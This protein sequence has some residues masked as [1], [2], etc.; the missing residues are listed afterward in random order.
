MSTV[1]ISTVDSYDDNGV[2]SVVDRSTEGNNVND[3]VFHYSRSRSGVVVKLLACRLRRLRFDSRPR[4]YGFSDRLF[5]TSQS[6]YG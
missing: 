1:D 2:L 6:R 4:C 3:N 5:L